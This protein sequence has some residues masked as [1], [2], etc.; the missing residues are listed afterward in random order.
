MSLEIVAFAADHS[1][2]AAALLTRR[3]TADRR[4][5]P[6]LPAA[7]EDAAACGELLRQELEAGARGVVALRDGVLVGYLL[8]RAEPPQ[9]HGNPMLFEERTGSIRHS[10]HAIAAGETPALYRDLYAALAAQWVA[11]GFFAHYV[12]VPASDTGAL[13]T[14]AALG[15]APDVCA[16]ARELDALQ[17]ARVGVADG[18]VIRRAGPRDLESVIALTTENMYY[19]CEAPIFMPMFANLEETIRTSITAEI[20]DPACVFWLAALDG[21]P[22]GLCSFFPTQPGLQTPERSIYL[23]HGYTV[24]EARGSGVASALVAYGLR[25]ARDEGYERCTVM[26]IPSN[27]LSSR[28]WPAQG[29]RPLYYR[30]ARRIDPRI[31]WAR[32]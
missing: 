1:E 4:H 11:G 26:Y 25:W 5:T 28:F 24:P 21:Q 7:Y 19:H 20:A 16:A 3:H 14:W 31:A 6:L 15:F 12:W 29:F 32:R 9:P 2:A 10:G 8:G 30:L 18:I 27:P 17:P 13:E 22:V 23:D